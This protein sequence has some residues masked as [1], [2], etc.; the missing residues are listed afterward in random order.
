MISPRASRRAGGRGFS[1]VSACVPARMSTLRYRRVMRTNYQPVK[2]S[3]YRVIAS[4]ANM[5]VRG[6]A[7]I[8]CALVVDA[9]ASETTSVRRRPR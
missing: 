5:M 6:A 1:A 3:T 2:C 8:R 4:G 9:S 7:T